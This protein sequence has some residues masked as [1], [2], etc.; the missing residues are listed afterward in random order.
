MH[1]LVKINK[2]L[3]MSNIISYE[4][5]KSITYMYIIDFRKDTMSVKDKINYILVEQ[6]KSKR[7]FAQ[8]LLTLEPRLI[9]TGKAPSEST[10]YGYLNGRREIKIELIPY[11]AEV[12]K[13]TEQELFEIN[14][15]YTTNYN[16]T[17]SKEIREIIILLKYVPSNKIIQLKEKLLIYKKLH[18]TD[19]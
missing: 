8:E 10:I 16:Y 15:E 12:L 6:N 13:I 2:L 17:L 11:I 18:N 9:S 4:I 5:I 3:N 19:W 1:T 14:I 7:K